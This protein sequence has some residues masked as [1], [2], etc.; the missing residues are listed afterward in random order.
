M[1][2]FRYGGK[3]YINHNKL[4]K[5]Y[6]GMDGI[7]TGYVRAS[8]YNLAAS[9]ERNGRRLVG[10]VIG[11]K[12]SKKRNRHMSEL[13]DRSFAKF[14]SGKPHVVRKAPLPR[15]EKQRLVRASTPSLPNTGPGTRVREKIWSVQL[16]AFNK[17]TPALRLAQKVVDQ[18]S[19]GAERHRIRV[20]RSGSRRGKLKSLYRA[21]LTGYSKTQARSLCR[22][23]KSLGM[24]CLPI[25]PAKA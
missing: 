23:I 7:K 2:K 10:I 6:D 16:G 22:K 8:G 18:I 3:N 21:R 17:Y 4:M 1:S 19:G 15:P 9:A 24:E 13:L 14:S 20:V 12:S 25:A 5:S 11:S